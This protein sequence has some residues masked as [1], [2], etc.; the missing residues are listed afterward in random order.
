MFGKTILLLL[1][2]STLARPQVLSSLFRPPELNL[3]S[4]QTQCC[5]ANTIEVQGEATLQVKPDTTSLSASITASGKTTSAAVSALSLL[6]DA[7]I[8]ILKNNGLCED[9]FSTS[10]FN[11]Y[12]N[13]TWK[14]GVSTVNGQIASQSLLLRVPSVEGPKISRL[15]D[16]LASVNGISLNSLSFDI[17]DKT[18]SY[19]KARNLAF[20]NAL[21]KAKDYG[22]A[23][24]MK[25]GKVLNLRDSLG[26]APVVTDGVLLE[27]IK[28]DASV[29][30]SSTSIQVG[31]IPVNYNVGVVF[32]FS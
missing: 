12:P 15:I 21:I 17:K 1:L 3:C 5:D 10:N 9:N 13:T 24:Y 7:I 25:V 30:A 2:A 11:V 14:D 23:L 16:D 4:S 32:E 29:G 27:G 31:T 8:R 19:Q 22:E 26:S 20:Q 18:V 28:V 6:V